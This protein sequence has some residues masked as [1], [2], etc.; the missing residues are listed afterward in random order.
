MNV[1][2]ASNSRTALVES[3]IRDTPPPVQQA[4]VSHQFSSPC[5]GWRGFQGR[6]SH[7]RDQCLAAH[8]FIHSFVRS[9]VCSFSCSFIRSFF[10]SFAQVRRAHTASQGARRKRFTP[11]PAMSPLP[12][13]VLPNGLVSDDSIRELDLLQSALAAMAAGPRETD[14]QRSLFVSSSFGSRLALPIGPA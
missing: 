4:Q 5:G 14:S 2:K 11:Q 13:H 3:V 10:R 6:P 1:Q 9:F 12:V 7:I 8:S